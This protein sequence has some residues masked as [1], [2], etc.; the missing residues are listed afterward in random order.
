M[1][2]GKVMWRDAGGMPSQ[3]GDRDGE[4]ASTSQGTPKIA[5]NSSS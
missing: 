5:G 1:H 3:E 2:K 4:E